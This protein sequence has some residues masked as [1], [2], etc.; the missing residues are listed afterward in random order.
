MPT[1]E[2]CAVTQRKALQQ[3]WNDKENKFSSDLHS[4]SLKGRIEIEQNEKINEMKNN[5]DI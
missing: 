2:L 5:T 4:K 1:A 3:R